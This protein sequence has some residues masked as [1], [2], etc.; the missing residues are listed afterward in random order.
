MIDTTHRSA[1][2]ATPIWSKQISP[3]EILRLQIS[4]AENS[5]Y[6]HYFIAPQDL[7]F[8]EYAT[9]FPNSLFAFFPRHNFDSIQTYSKFMLTPEVYEFFSSFHYL[10]VAQLDAILVREISPILKME[11]DYIGAIWPFG[12]YKIGRVGRRLF[13][14]SF[15]AKVLPG[16]FVSVGNGGLSLRSNLAMINLLKLNES[17]KII[18]NTTLNEDVVISY[19]CARN[20][21]KLPDEELGNKIFQEQTASMLSLST[22]VYG[23]HAL[24]KYAPEVENAIFR[25]WEK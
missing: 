7:D 11:M 23:F 10:L 3:K 1:V 17:K 15:P 21:L 4:L 5:Q 14:N 22:G 6:Q 16:P 25:N 2:I 8:S 18:D 9:N 19:L 20:K 24:E 12:G 13:A